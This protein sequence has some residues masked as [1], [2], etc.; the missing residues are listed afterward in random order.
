MNVLDVME[1]AM[2]QIDKALNHAGN[3]DPACELR[4][5]RAAVAELIEADREYD[6]ARAE[7]DRRRNDITPLLWNRWVRA[8]DRRAEAL[9]ALSKARGES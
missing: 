9:A 4:Q 8:L 1:R 7:M 3:V 2:G 5:A 6:E